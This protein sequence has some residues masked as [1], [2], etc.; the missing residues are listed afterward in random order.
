MAQ[1]P[2]IGD[3]EQ[4]MSHQKAVINEIPNNNNNN[5]NTNQLSAHENAQNWYFKLTQ[6]T[7]KSPWKYI[8]PLCVYGLMTPVIY[9]LFTKYQYSMDFTDFFPTDSSSVDAWNQMS[10]KFP[11]SVLMPY[12]LLGVT[13]DKTDENKQ[14]WSNEFFETMCYATNE[15]MNKYSISSIHF[16]SAMYSPNVSWNGEPLNPIFYNISKTEIFCFNQNI[17]Y[18]K[19]TYNIINEMKYLYQNGSNDININQTQW[20]LYFD[21]YMEQMISETQTASIISFLVPWNPMLQ[22]SVQPSRDLRT[23]IN[24][25]NNNI[26]ISKTTKFY[27][28]NSLY[29]QI[30]SMDETYRKMPWMMCII[31]GGIFLMIGLMFKSFFLPFRLFFA[32][33]IPITFVYGLAVGVFVIG[34]LDFLNWNSMHSGDGIIWMGPPVTITILMGL[35]MDYEIFLFSRVFE[36]RYKGYTTRASIILGVSNTGPIISSA[37]TVMAM[38]FFGMLLQNIVSSNQM[39]F[40]FV[41]GVLIDTFIVRPMLVPPILSLVDKLNWW[42][43]KVPMKN[44]LDEYGNLVQ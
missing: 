8:V 5:T 13:N 42:P 4:D 12:Y 1:A 27:L 16:H 6:F 17:T 25:I 23:L 44:L 7:T 22:L 18:R 38:A 32:I 10:D 43:T 15:I 39:G 9:I 26:S 36:Y 2:S 29:W 20:Y 37:G 30:D 31:V 21:E 3:A 40:L 19:K 24:N 35:A 41:F 11:P 28:H 34:W 33:V 14:I